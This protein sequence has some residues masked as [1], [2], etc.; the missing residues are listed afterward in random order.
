MFFLFYVLAIVEKTINVQY[1]G[2]QVTVSG[3][4]EDASLIIRYLYAQT[5]PRVYSCSLTIDDASLPFIKKIEF[6]KLKITMVSPLSLTFDELEFSY[7]YFENKVD[8]SNIGKIVADSID[9]LVNIVL[10]EYSK[11]EFESSSSR[12]YDITLGE[13]MFTLDGTDVFYYFSSYENF[14]FSGT[15]FI[16]SINESVH[17][18]QKLPKIEISSAKT[19]KVNNYTISDPNN[20]YYIIVSSTTPC[21]FS[22]ENG[23][24]PLRLT[25]ISLDNIRKKVDEPDWWYATRAMCA[26]V[27]VVAKKIG[28]RYI[29]PTDISM[30][31][32]IV[33]KKEE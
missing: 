26:F 14:V 30:I 1:D 29:V 32:G 2:A 7:S 11:L 17:D 21:T 15:D 3:I 9:D 18:V 19:I 24:F 22:F 31:H 28:A 33:N 4:V 8:V 23:Y 6:Q 10:P 12:K 16:L 27:L 25:Q 13:D 20:E 5:D